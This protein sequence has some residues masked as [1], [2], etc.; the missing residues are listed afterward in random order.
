MPN[1]EGGSGRRRA[2][3]LRYPF[4]I[5]TCEIGRSHTTNDPRQMQI[6]YDLLYFFQL[7]SGEG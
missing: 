7:K 6:Y 2:D 4:Q 1:A 3:V 5:W